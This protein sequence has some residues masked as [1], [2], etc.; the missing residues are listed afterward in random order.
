M[1]SPMRMVAV[2]CGAGDRALFQEHVSRVTL[3]TVNT[4]IIAINSHSVNVE[5]H[6]D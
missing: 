5:A 3:M 2:A 1:T 4:M 6:T